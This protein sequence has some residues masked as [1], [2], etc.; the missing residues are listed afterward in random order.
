LTR[1]PA[2]RAS[3][4]GSSTS[5]GG[6]ATLTQPAHIRAVSSTASSDGK[7]PSWSITPVRGRYGGTLGVRIVPE[8][9]DPAFGRPDEPLEEF[10]G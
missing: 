4:T 6:R 10:D 3:P 2:R 7:P 8:D 1:T 5:S 9:A